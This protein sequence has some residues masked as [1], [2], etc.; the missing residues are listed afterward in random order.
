MEGQ[1]HTDQTLDAALVAA[2]IREASAWRDYDG[3][4]VLLIVPDG[5]RTA[6]LA[7]L[8]PLLHAAIAPRTRALDVLI[9][10]GTHQPMTDAAIDTHL[11]IGAGERGGRYAGTRFFNHAWHD[12]AAFAL[13]GQIDN[14]TVARLSDGRL[15]DA[16]PVRINRMAVEYDQI[17]I[18]GPVFPHE[19]VGFSGGNKY[20][21][22]GISGGEIINTSHWLGALITSRALIGAPGISPVRAL[23]DAAA[24][25]LPTPTRCLALVVAPGSGALHGLYIDTPQRAWAAA[26]AL[27]ATIHVRYTAQPYQRALAVMPVMYQDMWT[28][29]KGMYKLEPAIAD[30]GEVVIYAPHITT[31]SETHG[32]VLAQVGYHVRDYFV[33]HWERFKHLPWG[34]LGHSTHLRGDGSYDA[35]GER[36]RIRVTLATAIDAARCAAHGLEY[37]DPQTIDPHTWAAGDPA[38]LV[39]PK[40]G[41]LLYR[42]AGASTV[43]A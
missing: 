10:L 36:P 24:A 5:T 33:A 11:G 25:L 7:Q 38:A 43:S 40:A 27:S 15:R 16:V 42:I 9:A 21:F 20:L 1:G 22:P 17:L 32:A 6:P 37:C 34:V 13:L 28:A 39:V 35:S 12:P 4:R 41:E 18:C 3:Q 14:A 23:I 19:V 30:G 31:F 29:A 2:I 26:A 8:F